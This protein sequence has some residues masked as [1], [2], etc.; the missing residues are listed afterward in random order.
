MS[1]KRAS[2]GLSRNSGRASRRFPPVVHEHLPAG[3]CSSEVVSTHGF[4]G[5]E[6]CPLR[7]VP[8]A[9]TSACRGFSPLVPCLGGFNANIEM[10]FSILLITMMQMGPRE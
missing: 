7:A 6:R 8:D 5:L 2:R 1:G 9:R 3:S 10:K 4:A